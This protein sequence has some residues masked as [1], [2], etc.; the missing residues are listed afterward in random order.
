LSSSTLGEGGF[1]AELSGNTL[2]IYWYF[3]SKR[4]PV[5]VREIQRALGFSSSSTANYHLEKLMTLGLIEKDAFGNYRVKRVVKVGIMRS[6]LFFS[7]VTFP[8]HLLYA[9]VTSLMIL[10][11]IFLFMDAL[12][13]LLTAALLPA[14]VAAVIFWYEAMSVWR[15]KPRF[16]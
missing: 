14:I 10:F 4:N 16:N 13:P 12:S 9:L 11:F 7:K 8:K 3:L 6:F 2:S 15:L 1:L 5:G